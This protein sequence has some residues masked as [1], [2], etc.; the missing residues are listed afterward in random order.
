ML[1]DLDKLIF[2]FHCPKDKCIQI[3]LRTLTNE[4]RDDLKLLSNI[5]LSDSSPH[6]MMATFQNEKFSVFYSAKIYKSL[7]VG[8]HTH[9]TI[10]W[11]YAS[12]L[13]G[14]SADVANLNDLKI[15]ELQLL[16]GT[17]KRITWAKKVIT[18][19]VESKKV[20]I[21]GIINIRSTCSTIRKSPKKTDLIWPWL[22][23]SW[24]L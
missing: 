2:P 9:D 3:F 13:L 16:N 22:R 24:N 1:C 17:T 11:H 20:C 7:L 4:I 12:H 19:F 8:T 15:A 18:T 14:Q 5:R 21:Y 6:I 10:V 23:P